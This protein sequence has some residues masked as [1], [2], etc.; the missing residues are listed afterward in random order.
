MNITKSSAQLKAD[1]RERLLGNYKTLILAYMMIQLITS[2]CLSFVESQSDFKSVT[3]NLIYFAVYFILSLFLAVFTVGQNNMY[4]KLYKQES[5]YVK[6]IWFA[7]RSL[8]D[9]CMILQLIIFVKILICCVPFLLSV[10]LLLYTRNLYLTLLVSTTGII[11][12]IVV[13]IILLQYSQVFFL[14]IDHP[15]AGAS[16]L[17]SMSK[18]LMHGRKAKFFY[19]CVS[20]IGI[21]FL[22]IL[23]FGLGMLW[24]HPYMTATKAGFYLDITNQSPQTEA[25][26]KP[27]INL[28]A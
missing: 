26:I 8:A 22:V 21:Y 11:A 1:A 12:T 25:E 23:T 16:D 19:L 17:L 13:V 10:S 4:L 27:K 18:Q 24:A 7:F 5:I 6:D 15:D 20:F 14:I 9:K 2:G 28:T 3:G